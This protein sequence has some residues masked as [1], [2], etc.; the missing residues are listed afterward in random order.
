MMVK[1]IVRKHIG[2]T[3]AVIERYGF[4]ETLVSIQPTKQE[5]IDY[6]RMRESVLREPFNGNIR[7]TD[8]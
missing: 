8:A 2:T 6:A 1:L 7:D 5:A 3:W 4:H